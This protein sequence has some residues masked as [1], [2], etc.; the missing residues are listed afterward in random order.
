MRM[1]KG[2]VDGS[3]KTANYTC[4]DRASIRSYAG[5]MQSIEHALGEKSFQRRERIQGDERKPARPSHDGM[6]AREHSQQAVS[7]D[8]TT[9][10]V[11]PT[12]FRK[13]L[14]LRGASQGSAKLVA[15]AVSFAQQARQFVR[16][17]KSEIE[18]LSRDRMQSLCRIA[19]RND[20]CAHARPGELEREG[21]TA[22][23]RHLREA[24]DAVAEMRVEGGEE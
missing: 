3:R 10:A 23:V 13:R 15:V 4:F 20:A 6:L 22:P 11:E 9:P 14:Q 8:H 12:P 19:E 17:T 21:E 7:E 24:P 2:E 5:S 16:I 18:P 1:P